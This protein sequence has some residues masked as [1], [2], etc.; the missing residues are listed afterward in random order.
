MLTRKP[1][2][3][4][5]HKKSSARFTYAKSKQ[6]C[7]YAQ[8]KDMR[9]Q[10][11]SYDNNFSANRTIIRVGGEIDGRLNYGGVQALTIKVDDFHSFKYSTLADVPI[12]IPCSKSHIISAAR[13][14]TVRLLF[15]TRNRY[16]T[17]YIRKRIPT[18]PEISFTTTAQSNPSRLA[19][20]NVFVS[21]VLTSRSK[22]YPLSNDGLGSIPHIE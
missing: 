16:P 7:H 14:H 13:L 22:Y 12:S 10:F 15:K 20:A 11:Y 1:R 3:F 9:A 17:Q 6:N 18:R 19:Y 2:P 21:S 4:S 8:R 5:H